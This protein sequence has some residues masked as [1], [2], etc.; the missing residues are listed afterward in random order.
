MMSHQPQRIMSVPCPRPNQ[1]PKEEEVLNVGIVDFQ[2]IEV[3]KIVADAVEVRI[4]VPEIE[5]EIEVPEDDVVDLAEEVE[6]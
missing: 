1:R 6:V 2:K 5:E 3:P 4:E